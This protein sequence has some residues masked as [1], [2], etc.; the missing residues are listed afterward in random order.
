MNELL[1]TNIGRIVSGD[2]ESPLLEGDSILV[3]GGKIAAVGFA[4]DMGMS[5]AGT[6]IN[7][8]GSTV[9]PGLI[10][11]HQHPCLGDYTPARGFTIVGWIANKL[12]GGVTTIIS[13]GE[14][15][16]PGRPTDRAGVKAMAILL[17]K[18]FATTRP[19]GVKVHGGALI[20]SP[21][22][23][24]ADFKELSRNGVWL[25]AEVCAAWNIPNPADV[26]P[27]VR[28]AHKYG[29]K[30][31]MHVSGVNISAEDIMLVRPDVV[32]H[33]N[34]GF[35]ALRLEE[36]E[37]VMT[38]TDFFMEIVPSGNP[39]ATNE[40]IDAA[41]ESACLERII[42]GSDG[43]GALGVAALGV[44]TTI[45]R[46]SALNDIPAEMALAMATGNTARAYE[47]NTGIIAVGREA[48]LVILDAPYD[49]AAR[50]ALQA[51]E[52]GDMPAV[53]AVIVDG[54]LLVVD[55]PNTPRARR[56]IALS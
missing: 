16:L 14:L 45:V 47:L 18:S 48:D 55:S 32:C 23:T 27:M 19:A 49:S 56:S 6:Q 37:K 40:I 13:A 17:S 52:S 22:L 28:W 41:R 20:L 3:T 15:H 44:L 7:A 29:M 25:V 51:I 36:V 8:Q 31:Q 42:V 24:E 2:I 21:D 30:V 46:I 26:A 5:R 11:S 34:G 1:V 54:Q 12:R 33:L 10:D 9:A 4:A 50:D 35:S 43:P 38:D 53:S 39:R